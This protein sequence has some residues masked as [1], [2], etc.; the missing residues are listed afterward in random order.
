MCGT[1]TAFPE[2]DYVW[3]GFDYKKKGTMSGS[4][5]E[6]VKLWHPR[7]QPMNP[8][9]TD[10]HGPT[11]TLTFEYGKEGVTRESNEWRLQSGN[12]YTYRATLRI[13]QQK[14]FKMT[15]GSERDFTIPPTK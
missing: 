11:F 4:Y 2:K 9:S 5:G 14:G 6:E 15:T 12:T 1:V 8:D 3:A 7:V 13:P 10:Q